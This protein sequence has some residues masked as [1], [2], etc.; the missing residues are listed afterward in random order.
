MLWIG[1]QIA[2]NGIHALITSGFQMLAR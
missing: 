1:V 2:L